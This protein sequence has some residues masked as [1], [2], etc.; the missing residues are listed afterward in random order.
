MCCGLIFGGVSL[1]NMLVPAGLA[2]NM[3]KKIYNKLFLTLYY[4]SL[5]AQG[6]T[7][8]FYS[9]I[10]ITVTEFLYVL[11]IIALLVKLNILGVHITKPISFLV[12]LVIF[13]INYL[14]FLK[15]KKYLKIL[16]NSDQMN[17]DKKVKGGIMVLAII[18]LGLTFVIKVASFRPDIW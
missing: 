3:F 2:D 9:I 1:R 5:R 16:N 4:I 12:G 18:I 11:G 8:L 6:N 10:V 15:N 14:Y 17:F 7:A 13:I